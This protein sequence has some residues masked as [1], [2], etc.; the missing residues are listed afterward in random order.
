[1]PGKLDNARNKKI[2]SLD[3]WSAHDPTYGEYDQGGGYGSLADSGAQ[4]AFNAL[5]GVQRDARNVPADFGRPVVHD[6]NSMGDRRQSVDNNSTSGQRRVS[7]EDAG[8][9]QNY[10]Y[11]S[12]LTGQS[13]SL[14]KYITF[15]SL[16]CR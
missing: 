15:G 7:G 12:Q 8:L 4:Y 1:M 2:G 3:S 6:V 5:S 10:K 13:D 14:E 16:W 9:G 11:N